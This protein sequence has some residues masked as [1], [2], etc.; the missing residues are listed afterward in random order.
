MRLIALLLLVSTSPAFAQAL[1]CEAL[2]GTTLPYQISWKHK[3]SQFLSQV[4]RDKSGDFVVWQQSSNSTGVYSVSKS[5]VIDGKSTEGIVTTK[6][7]GKNKSYTLRTSYSGFPKGFD[8]R[9]DA[10]IKT[11]ISITY[12]DASTDEFQISATYRFVREERRAISSCT[13][14]LVQGEQI[15][16][17]DGKTSPPMTASYL[18][19]LRGPVLTPTD[20]DTEFELTTKFTPLEFMN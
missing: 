15:S 20:R 4:Y 2:K 9:S 13:L 11:S 19:E 6:Q 10:D 17:R 7:T 1:D 16:T 18:P 3:G 14:A 5:T 12:A 8:R